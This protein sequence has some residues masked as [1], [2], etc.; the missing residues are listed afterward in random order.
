MPTSQERQE[1]PVPSKPQEQNEGRKRN[2]GRLNSTVS[3]TQT[4]PRPVLWPQIA[5]QN[6]RSERRKR[7]R[8]AQRLKFQ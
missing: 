2:E 5:R 3:Q 4:S 6:Q 1:S 7:R 8:K